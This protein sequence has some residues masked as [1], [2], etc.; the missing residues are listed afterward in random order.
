[1]SPRSTLVLLIAVVLSR[2]L[3][4]TPVSAAEPTPLEQAHAHNDYLH[5]RPLLDALDQGFCSIEA[6]VWRVRDELLVAHD[7]EE[8]KP[9]R[10]LE[11]LYLKPL[12]ERCAAREGWVY[13]PGR[14]V[15]L[16]IDLK[17]DGPVTYEALKPLLAKYSQLFKPRILDAR[18]QAPPVV[19]VLSGNR[20]I[21]LVVADADRLCGLDGRL[22]DLDAGRTAALF[23]LVSDNWTSHFAWRGDGPMP[24]SER[25][26]LRGYVAAA[27]AKGMRLRF[28][29]TP[30]RE[31]VW[32]EL[33]DAGVDLIGT[34]DLPRL[35]RFLAGRQ[36]AASPAP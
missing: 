3:A 35:A 23:P 34:D 15:T 22:P 30:E 6:D 21:D 32:T 1:M 29:A 14:T 13:D 27:H 17:S 25:L 28:W 7:L 20:P 26:R 8:T 11:E 2:S 4:R 19:A 16:L 5:D 31:A 24:S 36:Q 10:T 9:G 12:A 33:A 18:K